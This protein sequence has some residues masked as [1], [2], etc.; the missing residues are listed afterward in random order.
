M[1]KKPHKWGYKHFVLCSVTEFAYK[2]DIYYIDQE[3]DPAFRMPNEPDLGASSSVVLLVTDI[4]KHVNH[5]VY[6]DSYYMSVPLLCYLYQQCILS[7][8]MVRRNRI[9]DCKL[10]PDIDF[11][12]VP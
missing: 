6:F 11:K 12:K 8:G 10:P 7:L 3:N 9:P 4:T 2:F 1:Q 5:K